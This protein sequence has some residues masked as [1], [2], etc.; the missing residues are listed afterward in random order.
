[1]GK[2]ATGPRGERRGDAHADDFLTTMTNPGTTAG[3]ER[4]E[5]RVRSI[6]YATPIA[7]G[8]IPLHRHPQ[9]RNSH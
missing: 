1:M 5:V 9:L 6:N 8:V 4:W 3:A 2:L 7:V